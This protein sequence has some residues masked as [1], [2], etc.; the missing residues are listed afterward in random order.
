L[1]HNIEMTPE[2]EEKFIEETA[3]LIHRY[4]MDAVAIIF[5]ASFKPLAYLGSQ[6]GR[7]F[8]SPYAPILSDKWGE[9]SERLFL[10][11]EKRENVDKLIKRLEEFAD[12]KNSKDSQ[13]EKA[14]ENV[15]SVASKEVSTIAPSS[16]VIQDKKKTKGWRKYLRL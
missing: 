10:T 14:N 12:E 2:E 15:Q 3:Q 1:Y 16:Q 9:Q 8:I 13:S 7:F 5:I 4:D 11:F 6:V